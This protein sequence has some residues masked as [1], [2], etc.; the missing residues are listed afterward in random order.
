MEN[1]KNY[2][3]VYEAIEWDDAWL[4]V[5]EHQAPIRIMYVGYSI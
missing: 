5:R 4:R 3:P 1:K 2:V